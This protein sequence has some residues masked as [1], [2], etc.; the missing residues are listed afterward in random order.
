M[1]INPLLIEL[2]AALM[3]MLGTALLAFNFRWSGFGFVAYLVSNAGWL[4]FSYGHGYWPMFWQQVVFTLFSFV[5]IWR[6]LVAPAGEA[7]DQ[8]LDW[9]DQQ[10]MV[11]ESPPCVGHS[12]PMTKR[13][14]A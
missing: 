3:G 1:N 11:Y 13:E 2:L 9:G 4:W 12:K 10:P 6:W 7:L 5:G 8:V 14:A